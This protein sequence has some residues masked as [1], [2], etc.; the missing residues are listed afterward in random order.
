MKLQ[1]PMLSISLCV[2]C[3]ASPPVFAQS[4]SS[5]PVTAI[6]TAGRLRAMPQRLSKL[7][8]QVRLNL[9][10]ESAQRKL[11]EG[12]R[13]FD[14]QLVSL[15]RNALGDG[16]ARSLSRIDTQWAAM[17]ASLEKMPSDALAQNVASDAEQLALTAQKLALQLESAND[18][19][20]VRLADLAQRNDMLAQ[21]LARIYLQMRAGYNGQSQ[22]VD[23]VQT[24]RE[25]VTG[26]GELGRAPENTAGIRNRLQLA[27]QQ[28]SFFEQA[29]QSTGRQD[30]TAM[31]NVASTSERISEVMEDIAQ[32]YRRM[33]RPAQV[34]Q[35]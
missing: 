11:E 24:R 27:Q 28:W 6:E 13:Q 25:F 8:L 23:L 20:T 35:N 31:R 7:Y 21:R 18:S 15:Q 16:A 29:V 33:T 3:L 5:N 30:D 2:L 19:P 14:R 4:S 9:E 12:I 10:R 17:R 32:N 34:A 1:Y 26:L 22:R